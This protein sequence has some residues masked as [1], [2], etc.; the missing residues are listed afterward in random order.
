MSDW[1]VSLNLLRFYPKKSAS[2]LAGWV[3]S[4]RLPK[5]VQTLILR[6]FAR[7]YGV[8]L[9][10]VEKPIENYKS[11]YD[12]FTQLFKVRGTM[13]QSGASAHLTRGAVCRSTS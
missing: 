12:F 4:R 11:L 5:K 6:R 2:A 3:A 9:S 13:A 8:E 1:P 10:E 7:H